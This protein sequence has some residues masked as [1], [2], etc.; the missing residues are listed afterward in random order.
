[1]PSQ[2][3]KLLLTAHVACSVGS[4]GAVAAFLALAI[5]GLTSAHP[6]T[7][8]AAYIAMEL[9]ASAIIVP[10]VFAS[11]LTGLVQALGTSWGL[12]RHYWVVAKF[13]L[14]VLIAV[15]LLLQMKPIGYA[16][17]VAAEIF[18]SSADL[19][20]LRRSFIWPHAIGGLLLLLVTLALS[21][22]K[23]QGMTR[24]GWRKA[25][26]HRARQD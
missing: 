18:L 25:H 2:L 19:L 12:L 23:P 7:V 8:R 3:R 15:V 26:E 9:I 16:A 11:L 5:I 1:M 4:V 24:Y 10:L 13:L 22:Y 17:D 6:Q 14:T 20:G 21:I